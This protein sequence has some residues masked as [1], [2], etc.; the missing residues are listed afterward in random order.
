MYSPFNASLK[1]SCLYSP[2]ETECVSATDLDALSLRKLNHINMLG[3]YSFSIP[4]SVSRG[5]LRPLRSPIDP[6]T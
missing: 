1:G 4:E 6:A 3:R 2:P 5:E